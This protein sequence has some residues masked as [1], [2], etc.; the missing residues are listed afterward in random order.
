MN[1]RRRHR[2]LSLVLGAALIFGTPGCTALTGLLTGGFTGAVDAPAQVYRLNRGEFRRNPIYW[3]FNIIA[4]VPIGIFFG[5][6]VGFGK[7]L[8]LDIEWLLGDIDYG[9]VYGTYRDP[10]VW[11]PY[12]IHW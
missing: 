10:S 3:P 8:A 9:D 2:L 4:F 12:T 6:L 7:G 5:P 11:R 1:Q